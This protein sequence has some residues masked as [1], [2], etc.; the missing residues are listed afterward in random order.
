MGLLELI[1][2]DVILEPK[3]SYGIVCV[4]KRGFETLNK[5]NDGYKPTCFVKYVEQL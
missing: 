5:D 4:V 2:P 1:G 3:V